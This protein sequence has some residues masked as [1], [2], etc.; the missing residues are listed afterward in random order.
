MWRNHDLLY[1]GISCDQTLQ[2]SELRSCLVVSEFDVLGSRSLRT[3]TDVECHLLP[4]TEV[5]E[6][7]SP[8]S[9]AVKEHV[10]VAALRRD[11]SESLVSNSFDSTSFHFSN[12]KLFKIVVQWSRVKRSRGLAE[13]VV[14]MEMAHALKQGHQDT[15]A[16]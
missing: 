10:V 15:P 7:D 14:V 2:R 11:E 4:F 5:V 8:A 16:F 6:F 1:L 13:T 12:P 9:G 3:L